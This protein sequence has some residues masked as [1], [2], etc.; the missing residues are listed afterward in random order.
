MDGHNNQKLKIRD[1]NI[2]KDMLFVFKSL[3]S[4][5]MRCIKKFLFA[6]FDRT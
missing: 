4:V 3:L 1:F 5:L 6:S 2:H